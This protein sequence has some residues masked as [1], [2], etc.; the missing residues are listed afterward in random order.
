MA[1]RAATSMTA[2]HVGPG[3]RDGKE[4]TRISRISFR[5][6]GAAFRG[7][8]KARMVLHWLIQ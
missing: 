8:Y 5:S 3:K 6:T 2:M 4:T 7:R 1:R